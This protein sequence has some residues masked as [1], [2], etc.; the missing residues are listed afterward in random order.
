M[1]TT[2]KTSITVEATVN[3]PVEKV[4]KTWSDPEHIV[5]WCSPSDDWHTPRAENDLREGGKFLSRMEAKDG[6]FGFDF[7]GVYDRVKTNEEIAYT[8]GDGR[9]VEIWFTLDG[10]T[11]RVKETFEA[12]DINPIEMQQGGW[13]AI[14]NNFKSYTE[15]LK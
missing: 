8:I 10:D 15:S 6:S 1:T 7:G 2:E 3:A 9:R 4:W 13:Q 11:T 14:L 5:K 12:E